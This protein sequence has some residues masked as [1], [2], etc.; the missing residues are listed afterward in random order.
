[1]NISNIHRIWFMEPQ[2]YLR[3]Q[4]LITI[5]AVKSHTHK[6]LDLS[7]LCVDNHMK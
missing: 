7:I 6:H 4:V 5:L 2:L 3:I 1:M